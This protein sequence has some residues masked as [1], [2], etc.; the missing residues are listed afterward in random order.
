MEREYIVALKKDVNYD[1]FWAEMENPTNG[2][3]FVPNRRI[4][5][6]NNR[7]GSLRSCHYS[8]TDEEANILRNDPRVQVV[9]IP[10]SQRTDIQIGIRSRQVANFEK[11]TSDSGDYVNYALRRCISATNP[12]GTGSTVTGDYTYPLDGTG[13]DVVIQDSGLQVNHPE[14]QDADGVSRVQQINWYTASGI[15]GTQSA[16]H[17]RDYDGHG[18]HVAGIVAGKTYGW[19]KNSRIYSVKVKGLEG[20]G[21]SNTGIAVEECFDLIKLWHRNKPVDPN[22]G[23]KRPTIVNMS[24]GY[25]TAITDVLGGVYRTDP[26]SGNTRRTE[27]G[28][29]G[30]FN[31]TNYTVDVRVDSVD[32][33]VEEMID[34][35]IHVCIAAGNSSQKIDVVGGIDYDN[36]F[37]R[38]LGVDGVLDVFYNRGGSPH[39]DRALVVG[40][41]DTVV[42]NSTTEQKSTFSNCGLGVDVYAPGSNI[43]SC[44]STTNRWGAGSQPYFLNSS[45][46]QTNI[47]GTSM[48]SPQV[49]GFGAQLLQLD[50][51]LTPDQLKDKIVAE[52]QSVLYSTG[53]D[54]D[55]TD[56]R[57]V[58]NGNTRFI[59]QKFN[60]EQPYNAA[61][62]IVF[63]NVDLRLG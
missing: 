38:D 57:S 51:R 60:G 30:Q 1:E 18:T 23:F 2:L 8:L 12:Y 53:L 21:D 14:F 25:G 59:Y 42:Y 19:A 27:F 7:D 17:Y 33:D 36:Y 43:M 41:T 31:G 55:Y 22:T 58:S 50:P 20:A 45:Y 15:P 10:P 26:W 32:I 39:S 13:V 37:E 24:W 49:C 54:N 3:T 62:G 56:S 11:T 46:K 48:A 35:G 47:S 52:S 61:G 4:D 6:V 34:E 16:N 5:I 28:M 9:D 44:T 29:I 63:T 40:S